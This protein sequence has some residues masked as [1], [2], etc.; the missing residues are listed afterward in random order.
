MTNRPLAYRDNEVVSP[1]RVETSKKS[2]PHKK[3]ILSHIA[4]KSSE[5]DSVVLATEQLNFFL[6]RPTKEI[7]GAD[8]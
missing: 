7:E 4:A 3:E 2:R 8:V 5:L 6:Y 1:S